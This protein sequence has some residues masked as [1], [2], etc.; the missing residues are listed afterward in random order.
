ML[1][2]DI[3]NVEKDSQIASKTNRSKPNVSLG[4]Q[5]WKIDGIRAT[6]E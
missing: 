5:T 3:E 4:T 6:K 2:Q 1:V